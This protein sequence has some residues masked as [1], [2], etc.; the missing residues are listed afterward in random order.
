MESRT[1]AYIKA[2]KLSYTERP[3]EFPLL[4]IEEITEYEWAPQPWGA[5]HQNGCVLIGHYFQPA[6]ELDRIRYTRTG[7]MVA[8]LGAVRG[9]LLGKKSVRLFPGVSNVRGGNRVVTVNF[10]HPG[11]GPEG[12]LLISRNADRDLY[13]LLPPE[14]EGGRWTL[15][16]KVYRLP[17]RRRGKPFVVSSL[18]RRGWAWT[19]E[20]DATEWCLEE[21]F[22]QADKFRHER[23][24][25]NVPPWT[26]GLDY[27]DRGFWTV[28]G[29]DVVRELEP[30]PEFLQLVIPLS[31]PTRRRVIFEVGPDHDAVYTSGRRPGIYCDDEL[32]VPDVFG[33]GICFTERGDAIV[34][35]YR[36]ENPAAPWGSSGLLTVLPAKLF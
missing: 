15:G 5:V 7:N 23:T 11:M 3:K 33:N 27:N 34:P 28:T 9:C 16:Q 30:K 1:K 19:I 14:E 29:M 4:P 17:K 2:S 21:Y 26:Y 25:R 12:S 10:A 36:E 24:I 6:V 32:V 18:L 20:R 8:E 35:V 22:F 31:K 13:V